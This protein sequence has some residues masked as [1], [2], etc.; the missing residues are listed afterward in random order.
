MLAL[1][2]AQSSIITI[3]DDLNP[4]DVLNRTQV[5]H[6]VRLCQFLLDSCHS[7]FVL[8]SKRKIIDISRNRHTNAVFSPNPHRVIRSTAREPKHIESRVQ[9]LVP[10]PRT[11]L[12]PVKRLLK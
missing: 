1:G 11:L 5:L 7:W 9:L 3:S 6:I 8:T 4:K 2:E 10:L 12:Q